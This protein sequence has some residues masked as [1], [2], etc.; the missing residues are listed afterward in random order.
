MAQYK[1]YMTLGQIMDDPEMKA[2]VLRHF[3]EVESHPRYYEGRMYALD[4]IRYEV[5]A[6]QR[7]VLD[8]IIADLQKLS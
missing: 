8:K 6:D 5:S 3:P 1:S 4:Q 7:A 2:I